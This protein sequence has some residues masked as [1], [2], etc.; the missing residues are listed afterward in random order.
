MYEVAVAVGCILVDMGKFVLSI[1]LF[2]IMA[3]WLIFAMWQPYYVAMLV[4]TWCENTIKRMHKKLC[5]L[6]FQVFLD[7]ASMSYDPG[8]QKMVL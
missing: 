2:S 7:R 3:A 4:M 6:I 5:M 1:Y 8:T